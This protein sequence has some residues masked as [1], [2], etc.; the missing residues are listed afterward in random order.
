MT[1]DQYST[2]IELMPQIEEM[3]KERGEKVPR[4]AYVGSTNPRQDADDEDDDMGDSKKA[5]IDAT[6]DEDEE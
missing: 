5:N 1:V 6:S 2:L 4:P 3:L